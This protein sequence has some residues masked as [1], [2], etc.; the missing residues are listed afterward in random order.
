MHRP[1]PHDAERRFERA[2]DEEPALAGPVE[3][4][5]RALERDDLDASLA[6]VDEL[7]EL[8]ATASSLPPRQAPPRRA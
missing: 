1:V 6:A 4:V 8:A 5:K 3:R 7:E 2:V